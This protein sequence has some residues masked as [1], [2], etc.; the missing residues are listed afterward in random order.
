MIG[1]VV[2]V[3]FW[4]PGCEG[5]EEEMPALS[6]IYQRFAEQGLVLAIS[7]AE[8]ANIRAFFAKH[9]LPFPVLPD[10]DPGLW[11]SGNLIVQSGR[12]THMADIRGSDGTVFSRGSERGWI[13]IENPLRMR[14]TR[15][16][17][18]AA[19]CRLSSFRK[20]VLSTT[21]SF[22]DAGR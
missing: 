16:A 5:C 2:L 9:P 6:A 18:D 12:Q 20:A 21:A 22:H 15:G 7:N 8:T 10:P 11:D 1:K 4:S 14:V 3:N 13:A 17:W 19:T